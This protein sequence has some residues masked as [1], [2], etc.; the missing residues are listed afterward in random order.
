MQSSHKGTQ[1]SNL[2]IT[3]G[4]GTFGTSCLFK[5]LRENLFSKITIFSRDEFKHHQLRLKLLQEFDNDVVNNRVRFFLGDVRDKDRLGFAFRGVTHVIHAA[6][7]KHVNLC[8]YNPQEAIKTN[9]LGTQNVVEATIENNVQKVICLGTDKS[10][11]PINLYGST[12]L[13]LEKIAINGNFLSKSQDRTLIS[14]VR[15]GN[16]IASRGSVI[17]TLL[18]AQEKGHIFTLTNPDMTR[19]WLT[20]DAAV[21]LCLF[22]MENM[23]GREIFVPSLK[24]LSMQGLIDSLAPDVEVEVQGMR[25]G[26]KMHES[27]IS[28]HEIRRTYKVGDYCYIIIPEMFPGYI[29]QEDYVKDMEPVSFDRY[30]SDSVERFE[31]E[32]FNKIV[33]TVLRNK[34]K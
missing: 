20:I 18:N 7:L 25:P 30:T 31:P 4:T 22:A 32:E 29:K 15:Y 19:F 11:N 23:K 8:E 3:G 26:E 9:V 21:E 33:Q 14:V 10:V 17:P 6:A 24:S 5:C 28:E 27:M 2:L 12:K 16:V 13:C 1:N 34:I